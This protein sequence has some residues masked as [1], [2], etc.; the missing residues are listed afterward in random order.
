MCQPLEGIHLHQPQF[1]IIGE[2]QPGANGTAWP[3]GLN[4]INAVFQRD[5]IFHVFHQCDGGPPG[6]PC[7]GGHTG[8]GTRKGESW[9]HSWGHVVSTDLVHWE[10]LPDALVPP[11][12]GTPG[13]YELGED[14]DGTLSFTPDPVIMFGPSCDP[15][16]LGDA[17]IVA[18]ARPENA[19]DPLLTNWTR[20]PRN[21]V[22]FDG[23]PCSFP[24]PVWRSRNG[25][26]WNM[27]CAA[28]PHAWGRYETEDATLHGP[29][30][31][32]DPEFATYPNA[33][34]VGGSSGAS[35]LALHGA[36][37][38]Q[39]THVI[40]EGADAVF[41]YGSYDEGLEKMALAGGRFPLDY[42]ARRFAWAAAG[43]AQDGRI[44]A[45]AWVHAVDADA[46]A[47]RAAG[48]PHVVG[49]ETCAVQAVSSVRVLSYEEASGRLVGRAAEE[50]ASLRNA[51]LFA[52]RELRLRPG[53]SRS[54]PLGPGGS[55]A[56]ADIELS[57]ALGGGASS[58]E[59][60]VLGS[61]A[62]PEGTT[63]AVNVSA[64]PAGGGAREARA[65]VV[66]AQPR[67]RSPANEPFS[68]PLLPAESHLHLR[69]LVDRSIVEAFFAHG[70]AA[71]TERAYPPAGQT[72][73]RLA[74]P[75]SAAAGLT[76]RNVS[77]HGM[78]CG[79]VGA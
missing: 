58:F 79:W 74:V 23:R 3:G 40:A 26:H 17:A 57:L 62:G 21:P 18:V 41:H 59:L 5:G 55:G 31:L 77:V 73:I 1:H 30:S 8:P 68:F 33:T 48:C 24:G 72:A 66:T 19:S 28:S 69:V 42:S 52:A 43:L 65:A 37:P 46:A 34:G 70:R 64:P 35:F 75:K 2:P 7:G 53:E 11:P 32:A 39:P 56:A 27:L 67:P 14:C 13:D 6:A 10:R 20:D 49:I 38:G 78:G 4:D 60:R 63:V 22:A 47:E 9:F 76:V 54:L 12:Y 29:W 45:A 44:L 71:F 36:R 61:D 25:S 51:T 50:Y 16:R 15:P